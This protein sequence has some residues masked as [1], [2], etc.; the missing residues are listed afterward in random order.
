MPGP[1][2]P[3][4]QFPMKSDLIKHASRTTSLLAVAA[5]SLAVAA[6]QPGADDNADTDK[7][8]ATTADAATDGAIKIEGLANEKEQVSYMIG[9]DMARSLEE[10]KDE[11]DVDTLSKAIATGLSD[12]KPLMTEEQAAP[13][14]ENGA[15]RSQAERIAEM[16]ATAK[17]NMEE[18]AKF[19]AENA[20]KEGV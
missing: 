20:S 14:R 15:Q 6:C 3:G 8:D 2:Y 19:L 12:D 5:L 16:M 9:L 4:V 10:V 13:V 17:T 7:T 18:G 1:P 11:I